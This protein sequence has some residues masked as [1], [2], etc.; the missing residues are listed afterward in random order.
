MSRVR[1][2]GGALEGTVFEDWSLG[3]GSFFVP[4]KG[5]NTAFQR[6][7]SVTAIEI[8]AESVPGISHRYF[9]S[10]H[11]LVFCISSTIYFI[12]AKSSIINL[13]PVLPSKTNMDFTSDDTTP[14]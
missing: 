7:F 1:A 5:G 10:F 13:F 14:F 3:D 9:I 2:P 4:G 6:L 11:F 8:Y 12:S